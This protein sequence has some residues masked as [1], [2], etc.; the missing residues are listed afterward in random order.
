VVVVVVVG[1]GG[2]VMDFRL[3]PALAETKEVRDDLILLLRLVVVVVVRFDA[4]V[5]VVVVAAEKRGW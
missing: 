3:L 1:K 4:L 5:V 2:V